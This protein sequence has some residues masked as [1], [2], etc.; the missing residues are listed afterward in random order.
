M[1]R[2]FWDF[3]DKGADGFR[4]RSGRLSKP[5]RCPQS[6][7]SGPRRLA[8]LSRESRTSAGRPPLYSGCSRLAWN[9]K[10]STP[11]T[12]TSRACDCLIAP[13]RA[14]RIS[15]PVDRPALP[16]QPGIHALSICPAA[17]GNNA[18]ISV[19]AVAH[20]ADRA[21]F[22]KELVECERGILAATVRPPC[23]VA[24]GLPAFRSIDPIQPDPLP[25]DL[26][27]VAVDDRSSADKLLCSCRYG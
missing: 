9:F 25:G 18:P 21:R 13:E 1:C 3:C 17:I 16:D 23:R 5:S 12:C 10:C 22:R 19:L 6:A 14:L 15:R 26:D 7:R 4:P 24:T 11:D 20:A 2:R 27:R 8:G